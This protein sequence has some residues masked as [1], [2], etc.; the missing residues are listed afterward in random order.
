[1]VT[2]TMLRCTDCQKPLFDDLA[3]MHWLSLS[4]YFEHQFDEGEITQT[5]YEKM[6]DRLMMLK[7]TEPTSG[8]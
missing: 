4:N 3:Y 7:P 1:M 6:I 8:D 2:S 5:T